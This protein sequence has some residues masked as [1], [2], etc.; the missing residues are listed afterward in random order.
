MET[1]TDLKNKYRMKTIYT[2]NFLIKFFTVRKDLVSLL[3]TPR[4]IHHE[5]FLLVLFNDSFFT[6]KTP[7]LR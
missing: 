1:I 2:H 3:K 5:T 4:L 6:M 7:I